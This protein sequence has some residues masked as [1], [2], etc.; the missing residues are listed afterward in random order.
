MSFYGDAGLQN[1]ELCF[2]K[3]IKNNYVTLKKNKF[4]YFPQS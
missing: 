2:Q 4:C 1:L 3:I